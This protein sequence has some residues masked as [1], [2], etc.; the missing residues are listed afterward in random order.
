MILALEIGGT[1]LPLVL[2]DE[3]GTIHVRQKLAFDRAVGA[4]GIRQLIE[5]A[6]PELLGGRQIRKV[7]VGFG[8]PVDWETGKIC[9]SHQIE[10][11]QGFPLRAW[12]EERWGRPAAIQN[13]ASLAGYAEALLGAG[14]GCRRVFYVTLGSG[15]GGGLVT[16]GTIEE[17][18][19]LGAAEIGHT[20]VPDPDTGKDV[21]LEDVCSGWSIARRARALL[22]RGKGRGL[23]E[24]AGGR[25]EAVTGQTVYA[26]AEAGDADARALLE[27]TARTLAVGLGTVV[28]LLN[29]E[30]FVIGGGVSLMGPLFW[31]P[32]REHLRQRT[33]GPFAGTFDVARA[34]LGE[35]VVVAGAI[36]LGHRAA[37]AAR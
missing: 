20:W 35:E 9:R 7:G 22:A 28:A 29:P 17:G 15:V 24:A 8:G 19:G 31:D 33:F 4:A 18:Q 12:A 1:K 34:E 10:G 26:A 5:R 30:R 23:A 13:D 37:L 36:L 11:W 14:R 3:A 27:E 32:L 2:G 25:A 16:G 21:R 6:L